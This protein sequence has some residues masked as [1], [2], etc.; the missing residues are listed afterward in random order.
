MSERVTASQR[1]SSTPPQRSLLLNGGIALANSI[2][3]S[4]KT[5]QMSTGCYKQAYG[6]AVLGRR[7]ENEAERTAGAGLHRPQQHTGWDGC[8]GRDGRDGSTCE[9]L[10]PAAC[11]KEH[12]RRF[13]EKN[14]RNIPS[15]LEEGVG[16]ANGRLQR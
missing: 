12:C 15:S 13:Q 3:H 10:S 8:N 7:R 4:L 5:K 2:Y 9:L 11:P 1:I 16:L 14:M 6:S